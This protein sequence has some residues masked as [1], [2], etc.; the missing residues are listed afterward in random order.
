MKQGLRL[1]IALAFAITCIAVVSALGLT[2]YTA[3]EEL[4]EALVDQIV[5]EEIDYLIQRHHADPAYRPAAGPNVQQYIL[6]TP[7]DVAQLPEALR[8]LP[9]GNHEIGSGTD[10]RHVAVRESDGTRFVVVYDTGPHETREQQF[11][12]LLLLTLAT[13]VVAAFVLG[14]WLAGV[15]TGQLTE[16]A[17]RVARLAPNA[18]YEPL[19]RPDQDLEVAALARALDDYRMRIED[20][21]RR[22]Q[23]FTAN[24]SHELRTPL[25]GIRTSCELL[26]ADPSLSNKARARIAMI[27]AAAERMTEQI[28][29]LL[30]LAREQEP[31][32]T[33]PVGLAACVADAAAV[34]RAEIARK[35]LR[36]DI[37][38][39]RAAVVHLNPR[40]LHLVLT[41]LLGN[42]LRHTDNGFIRIGYHAPSLTVADSGSGIAPEHLP[43][44]FER[45]YRASESRDGT[46]LGLAIVKQVCDRNG[47]RIDVA[48]T[49]GRGST[50][51]VTLA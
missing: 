33:Q 44:L 10:E 16:L 38:V 50:F 48:S 1:R 17:Q 23:E 39:E 18:P 51:T 41:N 3:S 7:A 2:L 31:G 13:L 8:G 28:Q 30:F 27:S 9:S 20:M 6:R 37:D 47:W 11:R 4:E 21:V 29:A 14:H 24:A 49:L 26:A 40:A 45:F 36:L 34:Y 5:S 43:R 46:G 35:G 19:A 32:E 42:A 25:T 12:Q 22:E 15:L